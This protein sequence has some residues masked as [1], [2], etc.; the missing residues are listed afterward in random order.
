[1]AMDTKIPG[2]R[3]KRIDID[4]TKTPY[5][6]ALCGISGSEWTLTDSALLADAEAGENTP[7]KIVRSEFARDF[8]QSL[9]SQP[10]F[11]SQ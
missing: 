11:L 1:M 4:G 6:K 9:L 5:N 10:Q 7:Q 3:W 2:S 8:A